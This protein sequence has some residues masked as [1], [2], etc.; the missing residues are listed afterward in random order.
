MALLVC[1]KCKKLITS[2]VE[3]CPYCGE[4]NEGGPR[5]DLSP[6]GV[7][8]RNA[9]MGFFVLAVVLIL[10]FQ[11]TSSGTKAIPA[12]GANAPASVAPSKPSCLSSDCPTG[13]SAVTNTTPQDP[14]YLCK[15]DGLSEYANFVLNMMIKQDRYAEIVPSAK[16]GELAL[17]GDEKLLLD[18]YRAKA[19]AASFEDALSRCYRGLGG[20]KV[21]VLYSPADSSSIYVA[22][23]EVPENKFWL[24]K[25]RLFRQ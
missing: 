19:G 22:D 15:T 23:A 11:W 18:K 24:P 13:T 7:S 8:L 14:F 2:K 9:G 1:K 12:S 17:Q 4:V 25:A 16:T 20:E 21:V 6:K 3:P 5:R 10:L